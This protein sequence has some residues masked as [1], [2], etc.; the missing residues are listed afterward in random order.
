MC[1]DLGPDAVHRTGHDAVQ[2]KC[3]HD[4]APL[5]VEAGGGWAVV[6]HR[7]S[8]STLWYCSSPAVSQIRRVTVTIPVTAKTT[9]KGRLDASEFRFPS[10]CANV[11][12]DVSCNPLETGF[13]ALQ[14]SMLCA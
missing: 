8:S 11:A 14:E 13:N 10:S 1:R 7:S 3:L 6:E 2:P 9:A 12:P 4:G 5:P